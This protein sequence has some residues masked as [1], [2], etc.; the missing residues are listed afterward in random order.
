MSLKA[1]NWMLIA[2]VMMFLIGIRVV[3]TRPIAGTPYFSDSDAQRS[4]AVIAHQGGDGLRPGNTMLA[5]QNA[6][7]LGADVLE[8]DVHATRDGTPVVIHDERLDRTTDLAGYVKELDLETVRQADAA[9]WWPTPEGPFPFRGQGVGVPRLVD[10]LTEF[11]GARF[12]IDI[13]QVEPPIGDRLCETIEGA[14]ARNRVLVSSVHAPAMADF[15]AACP[16]VATSATHREV[17]GFMLLHRLR[18]IALYQPAAHALQ[19]PMTAWGLEL[20]TPRLLHDAARRGMHV[21]AWT[22]NDVGEM[23][24]L[25]DMGVAGIIT[26]YPD[27]LLSLLGRGNESRSKAST[28]DGSEPLKRLTNTMTA[29]EATNAGSSS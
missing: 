4:P 14:R 11:P 15:R 28:A 1:R 3:S 29:S 16:G 8:M 22:I 26:D 2:V 10:V 7:A 17:L 5:F 18:L 27:R 6:W 9:Y 25:S 23:A 21:D 13:K 12:S 19:L 24:R 20:I